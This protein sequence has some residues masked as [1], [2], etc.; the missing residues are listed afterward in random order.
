MLKKPLETVFRRY[1]PLNFI[2]TPYKLD[3]RSSLQTSEAG[4][5]AGFA[6][7]HPEAVE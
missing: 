3:I 7:F 2:L 4:F 6:D 1:V 5:T